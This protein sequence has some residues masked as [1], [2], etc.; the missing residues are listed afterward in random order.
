MTGF[1]RKRGSTYTAYWSTID[2]ASGKRGQHT[3]GGFARKD[4]ARPPK[5]DSAREFLNSI[6]GSVQDGSWRKDQALTVKA[7]LLD[8][9]LPA[10]R[11]RELRPATLDQYGNVVSSW[12]VPNLGGVRVTA[13]TPKM[14]TE[15]VGTLRTAKSAQGRKGLSPRSTQLA[16]GVL[17]AACA[18]AV[19]NGYLGRN[20]IAGVRRPRAESKVMRPWSEEDARAFLTATRDDRNGWAWALL[21]TRGLRRGELCGLRWE[22]VDLDGGSLRLNRTRVVVDGKAVESTPKTAAGRRTVSLDGSL[23]ALLR[24]HRTRQA[25][26]RLAGGPAYGV[27]GWLFADELGQPYHPESLSAWFESKVSD[28]ELPRIRLH[29]MRHTAASLMLAS[30]VPVKVVSEMLGHASPTITLSIYA[31]VM[32]GMAE[33]AGAALSAALLS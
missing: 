9:W 11:S 20:P 10:Q 15:L 24:S 29:D 2:P 21:L 5:G 6:V 23:V 25:T 26:E 12:I 18:W 28:L 3:K 22:D 27:G 31:H 7:L 32:P 13:L 30:G 17:K 8:H 19:E 33:E 1:I 14:V 4:P 16:V